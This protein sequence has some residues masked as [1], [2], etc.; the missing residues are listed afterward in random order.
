LQATCFAYTFLTYL[1]VSNS[2]HCNK[3]AAIVIL[4][5]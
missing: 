5:K 1:W 4:C 2:L 3:S